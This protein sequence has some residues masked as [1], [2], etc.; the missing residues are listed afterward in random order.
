MDLYIGSI[1]QT[2]KNITRLLDNLLETDE[3]QETIKN[4]IEMSAR[5]KGLL[6]KYKNLREQ[7][8][9]DSDDEVRS[10]RQ[11]AS[12]LSKTELF[13]L[14][15][16]NGQ[17]DKKT[18][19]EQTMAALQDLVVKRG[20]LQSV[21]ESGSDNSLEDADELFIQ[22]EEC[23]IC[24]QDYPIK[25]FRSLPCGH[26]YCKFVSILNSFLFEFVLI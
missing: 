25:N 1:L 4:L 6:D 26:K 14:L 8:H 24:L 23:I 22:E 5:M 7:Y 2:D 12:R 11:L 21:D 20:I 16:Q 19:K 15:E 3:D 18:E 9:M 13:D 17:V 10:A